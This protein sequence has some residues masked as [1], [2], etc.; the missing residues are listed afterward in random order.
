[1]DGWT[2]LWKLESIGGLGNIATPPRRKRP[3]R[4]KPINHQ[5]YCDA[6][7]HND[8]DDDGN[9]SDG[10]VESSDEDGKEEEEEEEEEEN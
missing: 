10:S 9:C 8:D 2:L 4:P 5:R 1:M 7:L 6:E 3:A